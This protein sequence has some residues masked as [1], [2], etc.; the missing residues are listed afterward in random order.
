M[1]FMCNTIQSPSEIFILLSGMS[2]KSFATRTMLNA[3]ALFTLTL[4][5]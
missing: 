2:E 4:T 3:S 5:F 1:L